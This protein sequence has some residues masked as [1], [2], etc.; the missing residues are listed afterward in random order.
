VLA[1]HFWEHREADNNETL[2]SFLKKHYAQTINHSDDKHGDHQHLPFKTADCHFAHL[3]IILQP[4][5]ALSDNLFGEIQDKKN[6]TIEEHYSFAHLK[7]TWHPPR[8]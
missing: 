1:H 6:Y 4:N 2:L 8:A 7:N 5:F 3:E